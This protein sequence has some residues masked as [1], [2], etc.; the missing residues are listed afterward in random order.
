MEE[1][2]PQEM[3]M[4]TDRHHGL[5]IKSTVTHNLLFTSPVL[6]LAEP[7]SSVSR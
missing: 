4:R 2:H 7:Y 1:M 6:H 3:V 5:A